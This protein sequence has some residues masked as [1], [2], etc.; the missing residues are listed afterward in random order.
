MSPAPPLSRAGV[1]PCRISRNQTFPSRWLGAGHNNAARLLWP[2]PCVCMPLSILL[3]C[4]LAASVITNRAGC[5]SA[6][7]APG[8][9]DPLL[10]SADETIERAAPAGHQP[11]KDTVF[12][13][14]PTVSCLTDAPFDVYLYASTRSHA[15]STWR[16]RLF[17]NTTALRFE[18]HS[19]SSQFKASS[20]TLDVSGVTLQTASLA[21]GST[22]SAGQ[23]SA[24]TGDAIFL[25]RV[26]L[27]A[28]A[29]AAFGGGREAPSVFNLG[30]KVSVDGAVAT[31]LTDL[32]RGRWVV[33]YD[34]D[35]TEAEVGE[36]AGAV[37]WPLPFG[38][39]FAYVHEA[40]G[41][42]GERTGG[43]GRAPVYGS[44]DT[45]ARSAW[46]LPVP[47]FRRAVSCVSS[48]AC[49]EQERRTAL[50]VCGVV[51]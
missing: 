47:V 12:A 21:C 13:T 34:A 20:H 14:L 28:N 45:P 22:C 19:V 27:K 23:L 15:M 37:V 31:V 38:D 42:G 8:W 39:I 26:S 24:V 4:A 5:G 10:R 7:G 2:L 11:E 30:A 6:P 46:R 9:Y 3:L 49:F 43:A 18:G 40:L 25:A 33:R 17:F 1:K 35:G 36:G 16:V 48:H 51:G 50:W 32:G 44:G 41:Y 29:G